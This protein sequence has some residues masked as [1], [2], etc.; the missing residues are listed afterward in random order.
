MTD[1]AR[2]SRKDPEDVV[3]GRVQVTVAHLLIERNQTLATLD[4]SK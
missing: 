2:V 3:G 4:P 1:S